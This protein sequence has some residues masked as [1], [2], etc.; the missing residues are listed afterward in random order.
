MKA[1]GKK[2]KRLTMDELA[3]NAEK[4]LKEREQK[5]KSKIEFENVLKKAST[6]KKG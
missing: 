2:R 4:L 3:A 1:K 6:L 5:E